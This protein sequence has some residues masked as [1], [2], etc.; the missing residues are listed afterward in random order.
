M[1]QKERGI[2]IA[3]ILILC[4]VKLEDIGAE[5][6]TIIFIRHLTYRT[7]HSVQR[8]HRIDSD[9]LLIVSLFN[10][11]GGTLV[12]DGNVQFSRILGISQRNHFDSGIDFI[13]ACFRDD[14]FLDWMASFRLASYDRGRVLNKTTI[15]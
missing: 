1:R 11:P 5:V 9:L 14:V 4:Q 12:G 10:N 8:V 13:V 15:T 3:S 2:T 7:K 6:S